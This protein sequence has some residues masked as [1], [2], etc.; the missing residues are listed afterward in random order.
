MAGIVGTYFSEVRY[1]RWQVEQ[2]RIY[3]FEG[4]V[5]ASVS[6]ECPDAPHMGCGCVEDCEEGLSFLSLRTVVGCGLVA[7]VPA[8]F[9]VEGGV[10]VCLAVVRAVIS[11]VSEQ[12]GEENVFRCVCRYRM[13][14]HAVSGGVASCNQGRACRR[15]LRCVRPCVCEQNP[16][17]C[18]TVCVRGVD[19]PVSIASEFIE[20]GV[21]ECQPEDVRPVLRCVFFRLDF[22]CACRLCR[23]RCQG[24]RMVHGRSSC[25]QDRPYDFF[26]VHRCPG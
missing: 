4:V 12:L 19:V 9:V 2:L 13:D 24:F 18:Q 21:F 5:A 26:P 22:R 16:V 14:V 11:C 15:A 10:V 25:H 20:T 6:V 7:F 23:S 17:C 3:S 8:G 1:V